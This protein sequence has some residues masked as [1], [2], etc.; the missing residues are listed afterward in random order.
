MKSYHAH[1]KF[2][3]TAEYLILNGARGLAIPLTKMKQTLTVSEHA[4]KTFQWT[5]LD[6]EAKVWLELELDMQ[7]RAKRE[8]NLQEK[9]LQRMLQH[10]FQLKPKLFSQG[11]K[12]E[13]SMNFSPKW[14][15]GS[16]ST[17]ISLISQWA[18]VDGMI[19]QLKF[20]GGS[21]YDVVCATAANPIIYSLAQG[22]HQVS[23]VSW[24]PE[25]R[26]HLYFIYLGQKQNTRESL[27]A[28]K[29]KLTKISSDDMHLANLFTRDFLK[30]NSLPQFQ[31][32]MME[33]E[34]FISSLI[35]LPTIQEERFPEFPGAIKSLG[36][37]GGD[38]IMA[39]CEFDP[40]DFFHD[41]G[42][43]LIFKW[44]DLV[45]PI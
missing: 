39:A 26:E 31:L 7:F 16:S 40:S 24:S 18:G 12:F 22:K 11:L 1:G 33:H 34:R 20:F 41:E 2:L 35:G 43:G 27:T 36:A 21:G 10:L 9:L 15:M 30:C 14:G 19:L 42:Y 32:L 28:V 29:E 5:A 25:F 3:I 8:L 37:W 17:L 13:T 38:F 44:D 4:E 45:E 23:H 6:H